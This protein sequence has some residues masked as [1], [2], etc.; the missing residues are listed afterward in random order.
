MFTPNVLTQLRECIH[1]IECTACDLSPR[2]IR[3]VMLTKIDRRLSMLASRPTAQIDT[4][5][6]YGYEDKKKADRCFEWKPKRVTRERIRKERSSSV[7]NLH[8]PLG[9]TALSVVAERVRIT[10][11]KDGPGLGRRR[12]AYVP[13]VIHPS[14]GA[15]HIPSYPLRDAIQTCLRSTALDILVLHKS[16]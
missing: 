12:T 8:E 6:R 4:R 2:T 13:R 11:S 16:L 1:F 15:S 3:Y 5:S 14:A 9:I 7:R 10:S